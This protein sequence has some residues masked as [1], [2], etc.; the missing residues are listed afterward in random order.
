MALLLISFCMLF[1]VEPRGSKQLV[2]CR[3]LDSMSFLAFNLDLLNGGC[4]FGH[5]EVSPSQN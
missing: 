1:G 2:V 4:I 3:M 5:I